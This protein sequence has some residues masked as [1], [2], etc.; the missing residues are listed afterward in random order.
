MQKPRATKFCTVDANIFGSRGLNLLHASLLV[1]RIWR[2]LLDFWKVRAILVGT[3]RV[4][5]FD[6]PVFSHITVSHSPCFERQVNTG[7]D[8]SFQNLRSTVHVLIN[9]RLKNTWVLPTAN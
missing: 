1:P 8:C 6:G 7:N 4:L 9:L 5:R 2:Y 3:I